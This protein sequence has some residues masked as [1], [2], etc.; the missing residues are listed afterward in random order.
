MNGVAH[1][2][3]IIQVTFL[4]TL[5]FSCTEGELPSN[6][7]I[8]D[9]IDDV[10][11]NESANLGR[12]VKKKVLFIGISGCSGEALK[13]AS[14]A[15]I[16]DIL[17]RSIYSFETFMNAPT[18][19]GTGWATMLTGVWSEKHG[20]VDHTFAN[21]NFSRYP[22]IFKYIEEEAPEKEIISITS[23]DL[24]NDNIV[25]NA[26]VKINTMGGDKVATDSAVSYLTHK[27]PDVLFL[28][29]NTV[30]S[31]MEQHGYDTSPNSHYMESINVVDG[32]VGEL[33]DAVES[34]QEEYNEDW[35]VII[36]SSHSNLGKEHELDGN[37]FSIF[38]N[39]DFWPEEIIAH[40]PDTNHFIHFEN[41]SQYAFL[42]RNTDQDG[43]F[44]FDKFEEFSVV[45]SVKSS[46]FNGYNSLLAN[47][48]WNWGG[49]PGW[50]MSV[51]GSGVNS[52]G[53]F[54]NVADGENRF[55]VYPNGAPNL[56]DGNW[57]T[58]AFTV[59]QAGILK[60]YQDNIFYNSEDVS[61]LK[62]WNNESWRSNLLSTIGDVSGNGYGTSDLTVANIKIWDRELSENE[63][64]NYSACDSKDQF[65]ENLIVW[66]KANDR[67][68]TMWKDHG[69]YQLDMEISSLGGATTWKPDNVD[70]CNNRIPPRVLP[71]YAVDIAPTL[72][73]W[74]NI[75]I[76][77]SADFDGENRVP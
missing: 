29:L 31:A 30:H 45:L 26:D 9:K 70:L 25:T 4:L 17:P 22:A 60:L 15:R 71:I 55:D 69:P 66:W 13:L 19:D 39:K 18:V 12:E 38:Y 11:G 20:A 44:D 6:F 34:R 40:E 37:L 74:L 32:Y 58:I 3:G 5:I 64:L 75:S 8:P 49:A 24:I 72:L 43:V 1:I 35:L 48:D 14:P 23:W 41:G 68:G 54:F 59:N 42:A 76:N 27:N 61:A 65:P 21:N 46:S 73:K 57:H 10:E 53:W 50:V 36:A 33:L 47:K 67:K 56:T 52:Q 28:E 2:F 77:P 51:D 16:D 63:M 7:I 62:S